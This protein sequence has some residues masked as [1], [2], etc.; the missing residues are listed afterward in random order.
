MPDGSLYA[1]FDGDGKVI[2]SSPTAGIADLALQRDGKIVTAG[3]SNDFGI[4]RFNVDG[5][6]DRTFGGDGS[7]SAPFPPFKVRGPPRLLSS[8]TAKSS[9]PA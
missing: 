2:V 1:A 9:R 5:S 7:A 3:G 4:A 8:A 6:V